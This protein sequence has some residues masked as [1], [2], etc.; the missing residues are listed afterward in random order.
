MLKPFAAALLILAA[1]ASV[2][3]AQ[4]T[5]PASLA[6]K[7]EVKLEPAQGMPAGKAAA[8][9]A[10]EL[11]RP[12]V[13][14]HLA[15]RFGPRGRPVKGRL[16][17]SLKQRPWP[18]LWLFRPRG[19]PGPWW[20]AEEAIVSPG[21]PAPGQEAS[22]GLTAWGLVPAQAAAVLSGPASV[23]QKRLTRLKT[24]NLPPEVKMRLLAGRIQEGDNLWWVQLAWGKPQRSF[25]VNYLSDEQHYI[26][27]RP[28]R[29]IILRFVGGRL[30]PPISK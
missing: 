12:G 14:V 1:L 7:S 26:Y 4:E 5:P 17:K 23:H 21:D 10:L 16:I 20:V 30:I 27:L 2:A 29:P 8:F 15:A 3:P 6:L 25:M 9:S 28:G 18:R 24:A 11:I 19:L 13:K 22:V